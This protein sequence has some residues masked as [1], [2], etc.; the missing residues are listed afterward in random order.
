MNVLLWMY[1]PRGDRTSMVGLAA[2]DETGGMA[3]G[4]W[5]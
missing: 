3:T 2:A 5:R 1:G 4:G